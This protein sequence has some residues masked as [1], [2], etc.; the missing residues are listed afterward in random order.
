MFK[1]VL[2]LY[3]IF[4]YL[5][6]IIPLSDTITIFQFFEGGITVCQSIRLVLILERFQGVHY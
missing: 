3:Y 6:E 5:K 1:Y 2:I 4:Y